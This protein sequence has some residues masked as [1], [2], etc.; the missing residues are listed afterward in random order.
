[1]MSKN[2]ITAII[3]A[4]VLIS[5]AAEADHGKK[6]GRPSHGGPAWEAL[7]LTEAQR[8]K[9]EDMHLS[10]A[11]EMARLRADLQVARIDLRASMKPADP[12]WPEVKK[13][14]AQV[15]GVRSKM[16]ESRVD[17]RLSLKKILSKE[18]LEKLRHMNRGGHRMRGPGPDHRGGP[19]QRHRRW[20][21][22]GDTDLGAA[23]TEP[24]GKM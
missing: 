1:M 15:N 23:K 6:R 19:Q 22:P 14:V 8:G 12:N 5:A 10:R 9:L 13:R 4:V 17:H 3:A 16:L 20:F 7:D 2:L 11:K 18:Q 21:Q 24:S